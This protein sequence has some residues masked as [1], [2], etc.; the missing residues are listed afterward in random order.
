MN[1]FVRSRPS[2]DYTLHRLDDMIHY[3]RKQERI[4]IDT[5]GKMLRLYGG[6]LLDGLMNFNCN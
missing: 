4:D 2:I 1:D 6:Y 3:T 5:P